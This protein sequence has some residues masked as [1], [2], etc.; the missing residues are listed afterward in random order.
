MWNV[1]L[2]TK[3]RWHR[4]EVA[5]KSGEMASISDGRTPQIGLS[6]DQDQHPGGILSARGK[7]TKYEC[8]EEGN[9]AWE[10]E[11]SCPGWACHG[12]L[13]TVLRGAAGAVEIPLPTS[14]QARSS[15]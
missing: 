12:I 4:A 7:S 15:A 3:N 14:V 13:T 2:N 10:C 11:A 6:L 1:L 8:N 9:T 5:K